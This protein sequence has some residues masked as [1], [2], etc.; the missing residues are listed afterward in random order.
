MSSSSSI[1]DQLMLSPD[2]NILS[3]ITWKQSQYQEEK[4]WLE[5]DYS[6]KALKAW[7][8]SAAY[9]F[10]NIDRYLTITGYL[11]CTDEFDEE[12]EEMNP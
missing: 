11:F 6:P 12:F 8:E 2:E 1:K 9:F 3:L 4:S 10:Q 7:E 5:D